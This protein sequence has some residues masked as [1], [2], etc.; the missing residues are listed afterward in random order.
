MTLVH[1]QPCFCKVTVT[2]RGDYHLI[3]YLLR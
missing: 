2:F 1:D 3:V